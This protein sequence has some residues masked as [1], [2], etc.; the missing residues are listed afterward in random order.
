MRN[1][2]KNWK[3]KKVVL[4]K[5]PL[6]AT[7][8]GLYCTFSSLIH[9]DEPCLIIHHLEATSYLCLNILSTFQSFT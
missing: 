1:I 7:D 8:S 9:N 6:N 3:K 4:Q 5:L 2:Q